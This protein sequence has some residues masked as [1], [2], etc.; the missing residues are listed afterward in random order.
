MTLPVEFGIMEVQGDW[1]RNT[2]SKQVTT[3]DGSDPVEAE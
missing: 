3:C 1:V 2:S